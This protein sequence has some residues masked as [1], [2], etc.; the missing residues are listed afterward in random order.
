M[1]KKSIEDRFSIDMDTYLNGT[2]NES[3]LKSEEYNEL[4]ELGKKLVDNDFSKDSNK[5]AVFN[6]ALKNINE[7]KGDNIMKSSRKSKRLTTIAASI[8]LVCVVSVSLTQTSFGQDLMGKVIKKISLGHIAAI[9]E[10]ASKQESFV[11]PSELKGKIFDEDGNEVKEFSKKYKGK[12]Y[13]SDGEEIEDMSGGTI[14]TVA[15]YEK[16]RKETTLVVKNSDE[17]NKYTCFNVILPSYL[18]EGY[19]FDRAEFYKNADGVVKGTKYIDL[20]FKD[21]KKEIFMQQRFAD[22]ETGYVDG[23]D[24]KIEKIKIN[25]VDAILMDNRNIDW[26]YNGVI[27]GISGRGEV[28]KSELIK[29]AES[30]K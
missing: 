21:G 2:K 14:T 10:E 6:K 4:L 30:I 20:Y 27:Y 22:E 9:Q 3:Q 1:N 8:T 28:T 15:E 26:E 19:E 17:L 5:E 18:P 29:I 13:T 12:Y 23:T 25:D 11:V 16:E 7:Y 24:G